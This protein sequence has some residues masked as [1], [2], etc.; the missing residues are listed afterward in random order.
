MNFNDNPSPYFLGLFMYLPYLFLC[1]NLVLITNSYFQTYKK[2]NFFSDNLFIFVLYIKRLF[3]FPT[4]IVWFYNSGK[5]QNFWRT[6]TPSF[7]SSGGEHPLLTVTRTSRVR[8]PVISTLVFVGIPL[9]VLPLCPGH[10]PCKW[11]VSL[12]PG[13]EVCLVFY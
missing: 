5:T 2:D 1:I 6:F 11:E 7:Y 3:V 8:V 10:L 12:C 4:V 9:S 13:I